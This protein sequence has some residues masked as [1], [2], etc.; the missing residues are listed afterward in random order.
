[1]LHNAIPVFG[2]RL[3]VYR[4]GYARSGTDTPNWSCGR[5]QTKTTPVGLAGSGDTGIT[6][7]SPNIKMLPGKRVTDRFSFDLPTPA[8]P[9]LDRQ[10]LVS[11][12]QSGPDYTQRG[13]QENNRFPFDRLINV[14]GARQTTTGFGDTAG[15]HPN[16]RWGQ[17]T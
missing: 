4:D 3:P 6:G 17:G 10:T 16:Y 1:M 7:L 9:G 13:K 5:G 2:T 15:E 8:Y 14:S 12:T 11:G